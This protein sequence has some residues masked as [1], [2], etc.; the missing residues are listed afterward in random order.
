MPEEID[1][2]SKMGAE[3]VPRALWHV[4]DHKT[5]VRLCSGK[6][7]HYYHLASYCFKDCSITFERLKMKCQVPIM[8]KVGLY[9]V[10]KVRSVRG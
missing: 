7:A 9:N 5:N 3:S 1:E 6:Y 8:I 4:I 2:G 10:T